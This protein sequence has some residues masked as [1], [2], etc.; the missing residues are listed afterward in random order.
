MLSGAQSQGRSKFYEKKLLATSM[1]C[2]FL[3]LLTI[4][5]VLL[6]THVLFSNT[7]FRLCIQTAVWHLDRFA[8]K[9]TANELAALFIW[10]QRLHRVTLN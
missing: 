8:K 2:V 5:F 3:S 1:F 9:L 10:N 6:V 4:L 7:D